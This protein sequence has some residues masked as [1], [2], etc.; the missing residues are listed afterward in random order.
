MM[1]LSFGGVNIGSNKPK[2]KDHE[3]EASV[4]MLDAIN[5]QIVAGQQERLVSPSPAGSPSSASEEGG[6]E[7][8]IIDN[9]DV[10]LKKKDDNKQRKNTKKASTLIQN[11]LAQVGKKV[12]NV[13]KKKGTTGDAGPDDIATLTTSVSKIQIISQ[14]IIERQQDNAVVRESEA[15]CMEE[16]SNH[17]KSYILRN[18]SGTYEGWIEELHPDNVVVNDE[19]GY[20]KRNKTKGSNIY[21]DHRFYL[22]DSDHRKLWNQSIDDGIIRNEVAPRD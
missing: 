22:E 1:K 16:I 15:A 18:P 5:R 12:I 17:L 7:F 3:T 4:A 2:K 9:N 21:I 10:E 6:D 14:E 11:G 13:G 8:R 20:D 19:S